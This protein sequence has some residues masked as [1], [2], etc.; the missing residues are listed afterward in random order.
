MNSGSVTV[1]FYFRTYINFCLDL[2]H[3]QTYEDKIKYRRFSV[4]VSSIYEFH[5][6]LSTK[7]H[8]LLVRR[9]F[10]LKSSFDSS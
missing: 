10:F 4:L 8:K 6:N 5:E 7:S 3:V 2:K 9:I 1:R